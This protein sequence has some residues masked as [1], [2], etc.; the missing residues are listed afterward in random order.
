MLVHGAIRHAPGC[1]NGFI[2][3]VHEPKK[4]PELN[5]PGA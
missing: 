3:L 1:G 4:S 2:T 5:Q